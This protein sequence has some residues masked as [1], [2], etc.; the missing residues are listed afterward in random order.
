M[1]K[2]TKQIKAAMI[3]ELI[4]NGGFRENIKNK[5]LEVRKVGDKIYEYI[6]SIYY[7]HFK[8]LPAEMLHN[9]KHLMLYGVSDNTRHR[10]L[11]VDLTDYRPSWGYGA[12]IPEDVHKLDKNHELI[13]EYNDA[14]KK[15]EDERNK[16]KQAS[17]EASALLESIN[18]FK[19]LWKIWP[20]SQSLLGKFEKSDKPNYPLVPQNIVNINAAFGLPVEKKG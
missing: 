7:E 3:E 11:D 9:H 15:L 1:S 6:F 2:L 18:T 16:L 17:S 13:L 19:Q 20:E 14:L 10:C 4:K 8:A 5:E 12:A